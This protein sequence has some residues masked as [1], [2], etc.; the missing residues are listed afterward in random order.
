MVLKKWL[1]PS[2]SVPWALVDQGI[3]SLNNFLINIL[4]ARFLGIAIYG[5]FTLA[6]MVILFAYSIQESFII[7]PMIS[8]SPKQP[9]D[10]E[11]SY[12]GT[13]FLQQIIFSLLLSLFIYGIARLSGVFF[14][15]WGFSSIAAL[16]AI[17]AFFYQ[18]Q[19]FLR[20]YFFARKKPIMACLGDLMNTVTQLSSI[21]IL[22]CFSSLTLS[23]AFISMAGA[24]LVSIGFF[25]CGVRAIQLKKE[26]ILP[27][28]HRN[29]HFSFWLTGSTIT[30]WIAN[31]FVFFITGGLLGVF[32]VGILR[33]LQNIWAIT[34]VILQGLD[35][36]IP[37]ETSAH[38]YQNGLAAA[39]KYLKKFTQLLFIPFFIVAIPIVLFPSK[40]LILFYGQR[41]AESSWQYHWVLISYTFLYVL[42]F[43]MKPFSYALQT[44]EY[45]RP[46]FYGHFVFLVFSLAL[47]YPFVKSFGLLGVVMSLFI[48]SLLRMVIIISGYFYRRTELKPAA[49]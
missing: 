30:Q 29:I 45:T 41:F 2:S 3:V 24:F 19:S 9:R 27:I 37:L 15:S 23:L 22:S 5:S 13:V 7:S 10:R 40:L 8:L 34:H 17:T 12:F 42:V 21:I 49:G 6:W 38:Y 32:E 25:L 14:P 4:L 18:G 39:E 1:C 11:A 35:N 44:L 33:A 31:N 47:A 20:R 46:I 16:M 28:I 36:I 48:P 26:L 43:L